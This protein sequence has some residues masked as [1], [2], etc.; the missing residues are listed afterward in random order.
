MEEHLPPKQNQSE[1]KKTASSPLYCL[2][3]ASIQMIS[4]ITL[5]LN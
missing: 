4:K 5:K 1:I 3:L 2:L